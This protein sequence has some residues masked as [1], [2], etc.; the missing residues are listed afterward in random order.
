MLVYI[1]IIKTRAEKKNVANPM[2][3]YHE[4][5]PQVISMLMGALDHPQSRPLQP[6]AKH[7]TII[8]E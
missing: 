2:I 5:H 4:K 1:N 6:N 8:Q 3:K 7:Y